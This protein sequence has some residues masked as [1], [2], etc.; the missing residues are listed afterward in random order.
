MR[1]FNTALCLSAA[2]IALSGCSIPRVSAPAPET[3][4][5]KAPVQ[6]Q[7]PRQTAAATPVQTQAPVSTQAAAEVP[8][9]VAPKKPWAHVPI[10]NSGNFD[11]SDEDS[12]WSGG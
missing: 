9:V 8:E 4:Q 2:A 12:G 6:T 1:N 11:D 10:G 3:A 5:L 7:A